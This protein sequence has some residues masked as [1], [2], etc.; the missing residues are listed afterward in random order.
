[1]SDQEEKKNA[2]E[3]VPPPPAPAKK[4]VTPPAEVVKAVPVEFD[5]DTKVK[6]GQI[7]ASWGAPVRRVFTGKARLAALRQ[8]RKNPNM[9]KDQLSAA[10]KDDPEL[11]GLDIATIFAIMTLIYKLYQFW[12]SRKASADNIPEDPEDPRAIEDPIMD[13]END[14]EMV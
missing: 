5:E 4:P 12:Q 8:Y 13:S 6:A 7:V 9:S 14:V 2:P 3:M 10:V 11:V 1:M